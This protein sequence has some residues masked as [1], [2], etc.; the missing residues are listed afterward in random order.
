[1]NTIPYNCK[2]SKVT[3]SRSLEF[4]EKWNTV[5][6]I[7]ELVS[8]GLSRRNA[9]LTVMI[10]YLYYCHW[11]KLLVKVDGLNESNPFVPYNTKA[12]LVDFTKVVKVCLLTSSH[13]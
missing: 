1:M 3:F 13:I 12:P 7:D 5:H 4:K 10:P 8:S 9:G 2:V 6:Q 11:K